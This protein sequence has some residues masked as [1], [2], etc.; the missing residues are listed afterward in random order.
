MGALIWF[1]SWTCALAR[2]PNSQYVRSPSR[3]AITGGSWGYREGGL[4]NCWSTQV[5]YLEW[6]RRS[7]KRFVQSVTP[8]YY[9]RGTAR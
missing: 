4:R 2:L 1:D 5:L 6:H 3:P 8:K 9:T 7:Q